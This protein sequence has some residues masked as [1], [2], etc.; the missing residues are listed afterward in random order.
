[1]SCKVSRRSGSIALAAMAGVS[2]VAVQALAQTVTSTAPNHTT[3]TS[4]IP[5]TTTSP[6]AISNPLVSTNPTPTTARPLTPSWGEVNPFWGEVNPFWGEVNPFWGE[7]NPFWGEVNPFWGEVNPFWGEVNP[8]WGEVNPF[9]TSSSGAVQSSSVA[10]SQTFWGSL[11]GYTDAK[12]RSNGQAVGEYWKEAGT[13][14]KAVMTVWADAQA[15]KSTSKYGEV[16]SK[17]NEVL[18]K[19]DEVWGAAYQARAGKSLRTGLVSPL[20]AKYGITSDPA[21]LSKLSKTQQ[22]TLFMEL[23][24]GLMGVAGA[25]HVDHWMATTNWS[26]KLTQTQGSGADTVIGLLD[27][28]VM[29]GSIVKNNIVSYGGTSKFTNG[30]GA[31][32][33]G[34]MVGAHDGAGV[35]G[36]SPGSRVVAYNP[37][38]ETGTAGWEDI[39]SGIM[40]LTTSKA[41]VINMSLGVP[42]SVLPAGWND[43]FSRP[44]VS[45][46]AQNALFVLAAGNQ[47][48][49][50]VE[51]V[52]WNYATNP[53]LLIVGSVT[54]DGKISNFSNR[55]GKACLTVD[56]DCQPGARLMDRFLVAPGELILVEDDKGGVTRASGTS[57]AAPL[58]TGAASLIQDRWPWFA[59]KP[60]ETAEI[61]LRSARDLGE[62]G[63]DPVYGVGLLDIT[64]A[65]S[66][67]DFGALKWYTVSNSGKMAEY[68]VKQVLQDFDSESRKGIQSVGLYYY[69]FEAVGS[70]ERDFGIPLSSRLVG[71][72]FTTEAGATKYFQDYIFSRLD[73][74]AKT[75]SRTFSQNGLGFGPG[76]YTV[77][78]PWGADLTLSLAPRGARAG[79]VA[80]GLETQSR[81]HLSSDGASADFG[82][83]DGARYLTTT[84]SRAVASDFDPAM[85][86][87]NPLLGFA[88]GGAFM[89][90][91]AHV[92]DRLNLTA[93]ATQ[94]RDRRDDTA[95][96]AVIQPGS[97]AE[98]YS[99]RAAT[100]GL[101]YALTDRVKVSGS[102]LRLQEDAAILGVQSL[103]AADLNAGAS[104]DAVTLGVDA[105]LGAGFN[106]SLSGSAGQTRA[107]DG[108][109]RTD[110]DG[111]KTS[112]WQATLSA[113]HLFAKGDSARL[114]VLQPLFIEKGRMAFSGVEVVDRLTGEK[115]VVTR[116]FDVSQERPFA[117][118]AQ[119]GR[120]FGRAEVS[121]FGRVDVNPV[122]L[123]QGEA[124]L[125][126]AKLRVGF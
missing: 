37:F 53:Q 113:Q 97:A 46:S 112:S 4:T 49:T 6:K 64:A 29:N 31:A 24:D 118:E 104:S 50:Q 91:Q 94:R 18:A 21:S 99:A 42:G 65:Q 61:L 74:W 98:T 125:G 110:A 121:F 77:A 124:F 93:G 119:Y 115:G 62:P 47:G 30:H 123:G 116:T 96:S 45:P 71:Q 8:F 87:A 117:A 39:A 9:S 122:Q 126:G 48:I 68:S 28:T 66:P 17:I 86:G 20:K 19:A 26:P 100:F 25:D 111:L 41:S 107:R 76:A 5:T 35:M 83:G 32:V 103:E 38:D 89:G 1:M 11:P 44:D 106:L 7:V 80:E 81:L 109:L 3:S 67:L 95:G 58:V 108:L 36:I 40:M 88:S 43:V 55:P 114:S 15:T 105:D 34:L 12:G 69:A 52:K 120:T 22:A 57:F 33:A 84:S 102:Y 78:N 23:Y 82:F 92:T 85:G 10:T 101:G 56:G 2:L 51:D 59:S 27:F 79:F 73:D 54:L 60:A 90:Y 13:Q 63:V 72:T 14:W 70:V 16:N 75:Q